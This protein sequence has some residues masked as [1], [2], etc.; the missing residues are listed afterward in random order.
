MNSRTRQPELPSLIRQV[1]HESQAFIDNVFANHWKQLNLNALVRKVGFN[2]RTGLP[3]TE[4]VF[5]L[6]VWRWLK[7]QSIAMF[8]RQGLD[9]FSQANKDV[10][11]DLLKRN[12]LN[13]Q[14]L[15]GQ[16]AKSVYRQQDV[17]QHQVRAYVLDDSIQARR[18]CKMEGV[19]SHFDHTE[20]RHVLGHQ[21]LTLGLATEQAFLPLD[22]QLYVG[23]SRVQ[24]PQEDFDDQRC[25]VARRFREATRSSK[26]EMAANMLKRAR[27]LGLNAEYLLGDAWFGTKTMI[28]TSQEVAVTAILR[29]KKN[30]MKYRFSE[31]GQAIMLTAKELHQRVARLNW[32]KVNNLPYQAMSID[33][34]LDVS[35][36][37]EPQNWRPV[38]LVFVRGVADGSKSTVGKK[39]WALFLSTDTGLSLVKILELYALRWSIEVYFKEA[40]QHLGLLREQTISFASHTASIH[41][42][43]MRY[44]ILVA[45]MLEDG[46][47]RVCDHR[48]DME[49]QLTT[50]NFA[51]RLWWLFRALIWE[52]LDTVW[53]DDLDQALKGNVLDAIDERMTEFFTRSL[54]LD[55]LSMRLEHGC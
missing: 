48:S 17:A 49:A 51:H 50:L 28:R 36:K 29:M 22:S 6:M 3:V 11:Y 35:A 52:T 42:A 44:L 54:Q 30:E 1:L 23:Q 41:L 40:K 39:D 19:S 31:N 33:V 4:V 21:V 14:A 27:R 24:A 10:M 45:A 13:W 18:G 32:R 25:V 37:G 46:E 38:R 26:P 5:L 7:V 20:G 15:H 8:S 53:P 47:R 43:A 9:L 2:K 12:D 34:Q 55:A 16:T